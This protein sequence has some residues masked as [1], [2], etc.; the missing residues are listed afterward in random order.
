MFYNEHM[1]VTVS[2]FLATKVY[3]DWLRQ[4]IGPGSPLLEP[5]TDP[6]RFSFPIPAMARGSSSKTPNVLS[7]TD[8]IAATISGLKAQIAELERTNFVKS[9]RAN[10]S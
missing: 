3:L 2:V 8:T 10:I 7:K 6:A 9:K 1:A 5:F 4:K